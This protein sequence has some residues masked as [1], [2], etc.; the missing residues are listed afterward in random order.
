MQNWHA[1]LC[2]YCEGPYTCSQA[3]CVGDPICPDC[4][5]VKRCMTAHEKY[6]AGATTTDAE[7]ALF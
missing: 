7:E 4:E 3:P 5:H 6:V 1:H 2:H